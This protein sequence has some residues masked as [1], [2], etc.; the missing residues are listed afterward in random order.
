MVIMID[1]FNKFKDT[2]LYKDGNTLQNKVAE[3]K[4]KLK[5]CS[6]VDEERIKKEIKKY[7][8]GIRGEKNI[9]Y[10]LMNSHIPMYILHDINIEYKGYRAQI[11]F[12]IITKRNCFI[13]E[14]KHLY[15][16]VFIDNKGD[17][18]RSYNGRLSAMYNP[19]TQLERHINVIREYINDRNGFIGKLIVNKAFGE[20]YRGIVV[21]S[22][23]N[24]K[25]SDRNAPDNVRNKVVRADKIINYIKKIESE[26]KNESSSESEIKEYADRI[27]S[28]EVIDNNA[29]INDD[30][31]MGVKVSD[32]LV[33]DRLKKYRLR[34]S[35]EL[36]YRPYY[37]F[38][39]ST[40]NELVMKR[41]KSI[42]ELKEIEGIADKKVGMYGKDIL[43]IINGRDDI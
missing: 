16:D 34:K 19:I 30:K 31:D 41:P 18:Y 7:E 23:E 20:Y 32:E 36:N 25:I 42:V 28:L 17:F 1:I 33:R 43:D 2:V 13:I 40:L 27:L 26:S 5:N 35:N 14:C 24:T 15:G 12:L 9:I 8:Y 22:N 37:I 11:D 29:K 21:F 39:D 6:L 38:N 10:E 3:L 4:L